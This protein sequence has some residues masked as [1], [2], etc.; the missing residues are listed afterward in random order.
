[1]GLV[2]EHISFSYGRNDVL[3]DV[4][5]EVGAGEILAL[6]GPNGTGKTTLLKCIGRV[7]EPREGRTLIDGEDISKMRIKKRARYVGYVPQSTAAAFPGT[8]VDTVLSGRMPYMGFGL[9]RR[10]QEIAFSVIRQMGLEAMAFKKIS[11]L[12]GGERQRAFIAR[13]IA[14]GPRVLLLDEPT[15]SLDLKNQLLTLQ[16]IRQLV[17][18]MGICAVVSIHDLNLAAMFCHSVMMLKGAAVF[19]YGSPE[20]VITPDHIREVYGVEASV[21]YEQEIP[22]MRLIDSVEREEWEWR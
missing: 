5:L 16:M 15:S 4:S 10:D 3:T 1:M 8:V 22:H 20:E 9:T 2:A 7:L 17:C 14:Q 6:L 11:C 19:S 12:S 18:R 13:A 21:D